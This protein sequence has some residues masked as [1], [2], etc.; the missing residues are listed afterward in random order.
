MCTEMRNPARSGQSPGAPGFA[1]ET[2][3]TV[4]PSP[5]VHPHAAG[6]VLAGGQSTRMGQDKALLTVAGQRLIVHALS[7]LR[8]AGLS[9]SIAGARSQLASFAPVVEDAEPGLGPLAGICAALASISARHAVFVP[10]HAVFVPVDLPLLPASLLRFLLHHAEITG[11]AVTVP[12]LNGFALT[13]PAIVD[14]AALPALRADLA[15]GRRGCF[16]AF[17]AAA[18]ALGQTVS[19]LAVELLV[20]SGQVDHPSGL[21]AVRW[22]LN[23][24]TPADLDLVSAQI[25]SAID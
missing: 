5:T 23:L 1:S 17:Q 22:F 4:P 6:F 11:R 19:T 3:E 2:W 13:F 9:A 7:I 20:Q 15:A 8:E 12:S 25:P 21:P 14:R 18:A 24:N 10:R 16:A